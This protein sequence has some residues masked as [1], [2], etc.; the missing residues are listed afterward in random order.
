MHGF[1]Q[2]TQRTQR[3][4]VANDMAGI[5][6]ACVKSERSISLARRV[7]ELALLR[8]LR[9]AGNRALQMKEIETTH[10]RMSISSPSLTFKDAP[11]STTE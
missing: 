10:K 2:G 4:Q 7:L 11:Q 5:Y 6:H 3:S 8:C 1:T 9:K